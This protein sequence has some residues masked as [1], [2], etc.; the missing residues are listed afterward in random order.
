MDEL[1]WAYMNPHKTG[2]PMAIWI[3]QH[4]T[5]RPPRGLRHTLRVNQNHGSIP[6]Y[7]DIEEAVTAEIN[8][9]SGE[10]TGGDLADSDLD[11][12][13]QWLDQNRNTLTEHWLNQIWTFD[14]PYH[15]VKLR[16]TGYPPL[17]FRIR[18]SVEAFIAELGWPMTSYV[19]EACDG[20]AEYNYF[21]A[22]DNDRYWRLKNGIEIYC[23]HVATLDQ[24]WSMAAV[25]VGDDEFRTVCCIFAFKSRGV[26]DQVMERFA[27]AS[28]ILKP[29]PT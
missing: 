2:L 13:R 15:L 23:G 3:S 24:D 12:V 29:G 25:L 8:V 6:K 21:I 1:C 9:E 17:D 10:L 5:R 16:D 26:R 20:L 4:E 14:L 27:R 28:H 7:I 22:C 18:T 11:L 19:R